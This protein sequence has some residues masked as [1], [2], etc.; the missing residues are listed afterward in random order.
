MLTDP[1]KPIRMANPCHVELVLK[2]KSGIQLRTTQQLVEDDTVIDSVDPYLFSLSLIKELP[3]AL[4][5]FR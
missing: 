1:V 4:D 5:Y 2:T 3:A